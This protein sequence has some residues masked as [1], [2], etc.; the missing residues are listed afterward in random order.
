MDKFHNNLDRYGNTSAASVPIALDEAYPRRAHSIG[1]PGPTGRIRS[2]LD[3]GFHTD[4]MAVTFMHRTF[5]L[6]LALGLFMAPS[7]NA[8][9]AK[10]TQLVWRSQQ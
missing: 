7:L 3:L 10:P 1:G 8:L 2:R 5:P 9:S 4:Q 6:L